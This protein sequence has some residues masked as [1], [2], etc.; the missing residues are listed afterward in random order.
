MLLSE[1]VECVSCGE[2]I[3]GGVV[4]FGNG[5]VVVV[6][7]GVE[8]FNGGFDIFVKGKLIKVC[9]M[10]FYFLVMLIFIGSWFGVMSN[11]DKI[12]FDVWGKDFS[13]SK[14]KFWCLDMGV[15]K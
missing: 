2:L 13:F 15:L 5:Y 8:K 3:V 12:V 14:V 9:V 10:G 11:G 7:F 1:V 4:E 6:F